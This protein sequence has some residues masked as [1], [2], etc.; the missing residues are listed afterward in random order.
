MSAKTATKITPARVRK[1]KAFIARVEARKE[2]GKAISKLPRKSKRT[3]AQD[4]W[5]ATHCSPALAGALVSFGTGT[6][7]P[8]E[9]CT[10]VAAVYDSYLAAIV[11][12]AMS[13]AISDGRCRIL[14]QDVR[15]AMGMTDTNVF[16]DITAPYNRFRIEDIRSA[17]R[18]STEKKL[19]RYKKLIADAAKK[20]IKDSSDEEDD[21]QPE[22]ADEEEDDGFD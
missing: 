8:K 10:Y 16:G 17:R 4:R 20:G 9:V 18:E 5:D 1:A 12:S 22:T 3:K 6:T 11:R 15:R 14:L 2:R 19:E 7:A 21:K 13:F